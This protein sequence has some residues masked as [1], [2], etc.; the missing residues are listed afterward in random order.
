MRSMGLKLSPLRD[1][2]IGPIGQPILPNQ[3]NVL[4]WWW[5][6]SIS[7]VGEESKH[8]QLG[9]QI[10]QPCLVQQ[11][12]PCLQTCSL[13]KNMVTVVHSIG[14]L[15]MLCTCSVM[16]LGVVV[17]PLLGGS[18]VILVVLVQKRTHW[19]GG[20]YLV[21]RLVYSGLV[22]F[23]FSFWEHEWILHQAKNWKMPYFAFRSKGI[24]AL[25]CFIIAKILW[26]KLWKTWGPSR[27]WLYVGSFSWLLHRYIIGSHLH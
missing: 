23:G 3:P 9:V 26:V 10:T 24:Y 1:E 15:L 20:C 8:S 14:Q 22:E 13:N 2:T 7:I 5:Y 18:C 27:G 16:G 12:D 25:K 4:D 11:M 17:H 21:Q 19:I 6:R